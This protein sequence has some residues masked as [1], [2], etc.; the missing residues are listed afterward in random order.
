MDINDL[1]SGDILLFSGEKGSTISEAIMYLTN[2]PVS[3]AAMAYTP[4]GTIVEATPP[5]VQTN[6]AAERFIDRKISVMRCNPPQNSYAPVLAAA[7][8]YLNDKAPYANA[9]L[10]LVGMLL[11]YRKFTP[12]T[13]TQRVIISI[14]KKITAAIITYY[15]DHKYPGQLPMVCSQ[16]VY[17]CYEDAGNDYRLM[18]KGGV[19]VG[20]ALTADTSTPSLLDQAIHRGRNAPAPAFRAFVAARSGLALAA[21]E[22]RSDEELASELLVALRATPSLHAEAALPLDD[23]LVLAI[24]EFAQAIYLARTGATASPDELSQANA[25]RMASNGMA[26]LK[27]EEAYFVAPGDL[28]LHCA[29]L[30]LAG[31]IEI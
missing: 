31:E 2:A 29:N 5:A 7:T 20:R 6:Q 12:D 21:P 24:H 4:G 3:H 16:L 18:I 30:S 27:S 8:G 1:K 9:N 14:L 15:N 11:V 13:V 19:L 25:L 26:Q 10:Y 22:A 23:A 17:Q 28:L